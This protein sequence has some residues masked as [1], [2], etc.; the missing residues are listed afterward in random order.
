MQLTP[1]QMLYD[2]YLYSRANLLRLDQASFPAAGR[3]HAGGTIYLTAADESGMMISFIQSNYMGYGSGVVVP[4]TG[5]SLQNRGVGFSMDPQSPNV[6][7]G[8]KRPFHTIIPGVLSKAGKPVMS[9]GV[10]GGDM[11]PIGREAC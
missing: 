4:D 1:E 9:F 2:N 7:E 3:P 5:I 11:P 10:I 6:V 8:G